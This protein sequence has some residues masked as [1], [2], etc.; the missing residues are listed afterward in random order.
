MSEDTLPLLVSHRFQVLFHSP[1]R[2]SFHL[3]LTVLVRYRS[4]NVFSLGKWSSRF[5]TR[6]HVSRRTQDPR[7]QLVSFNY[8]AVTL[9]GRPFQTVPLPTRCVLQVLQPRRPMTDGLGFS[10][11]ARHY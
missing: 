2:G 1:R 10:P 11:F 7:R 4:P 6:F 9:S 8:G 3:S 5:P